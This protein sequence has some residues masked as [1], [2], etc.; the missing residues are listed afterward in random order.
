MLALGEYYKHHNIYRADSMSH[1]L[2]QKSRVLSDSLRYSALM[3]SAEI[4]EIQGNQE[5][6]FKDVLA[7]QSFLNKLNSEDA[8]FEIYRHL[9]YYH[10]YSLEFDVL[11][12]EFM[13]VVG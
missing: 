3:Y 9:G 12:Q 7:C 10:S 11:F 13:Q 5:E 4:N 1:V 2:L 6:Y 8:K